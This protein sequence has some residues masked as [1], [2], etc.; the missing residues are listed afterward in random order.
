MARAGMMESLTNVSNWISKSAWRLYPFFLLLTLLPIAL[1]AYSVSQALKHQAEVQ[2]ISGST[3]VARLS[4]TLIGEH[5]GQSTAYLE[6]LA[7]SPSF[8][9]AVSRNDR[10]EI[11][12]QLR[13][14]YALRPDFAFL[15][16]YDLDGNMRAIYPPAP[17]LINRNFSYRDWYRGISR[18]WKPYISEV[19]ETAVSPQQ[20]VAAA[21]VPI[22]DAQGRPIAI[23]MA[24]LALT[25]IDH[26]LSESSLDSE[27]SISILDQ[28]GHSFSSPGDRHYTSND[29]KERVEQ[30]VRGHATD[31]A[32]TIYDKTIFLHYE[33]LPAYGWG[34]LV[35]RQP[36]ALRAGISVVERQAW[37]WGL[38]FALLGV[39]ISVALGSLFV[40]L[41]TSNRFTDLSLDLFCTA[42]FDGFFKR[43]NPAWSKVLGF[44]IEE[45]M[46]RPYLEFVHPEDRR[47][48]VDESDSL[49][50]QEIT[51]AFE[52]RYL[53]KDGS[54]KLL[55]WNAISDPEQKLI[56]GIARDVTQ[57][58]KAER[59]LKESEERFRLLV[60]SVKD[61]AILVLD[62]AG[63]VTSWNE[64]AEHIKG[65]KA[66][67]ILGRHFSCFYT[68]E[69]IQSGKPERELR[70]ATSE[71]RYE[72]EGWRLR[73]DGTR[74]WAS[75]V[76]TAMKDQAG[77][78]RGFAKV[79]RD[80][81]ERKR[82]EELLKESEERH[83]KL[84]ENN[85]HPTW[86]F[87]RETLRFLAVNRAA[88]RNY[89]YSSDE[90]LAMEITDIRPPEDIPKVIEAVGHLTDGKG[91]TG[92]WRHRR[93]DGKIIDVEITSYALSFGG[94]PAEV[95]VAVD[96]T[97]RRQA[98]EERRT[99]TESLAVA[100][101]ELEL[102]NREVE[103]ATQLKSKFLASMSHELRTPLNAIVGFSDLLGE[104]APGQLNAKQ[105]RFVGHIKQGSKHLL[106]LINDILD[107]SKIEAGQ[108]EFR[109]EDFEIKD[110]L[111]EVLSTIRPLA[112]AKNITVNE[113]STAGLFICADR[114]RFKQVLYNL[115]SNAVKFTP[116]GGR[117]EIKAYNQ[118]KRVHVSV[119]D[120]G[121][122]IRPED[123]TL[124]FE[125]FRQVEGSTNAHEGT[126]LG[127]AI[128]KRLVEEQG[129]TISLESELGKGSKFT[130]SFP[131]GDQRS[132][133]EEEAS[134]SPAQVNA[135]ESNPLVLIVDDEE[136]ARELLT[137]YLAPAY[138]TVTADSGAD[139]LEKAKQIRPHAIIL[140][141][142]MAE[143][144]GFETLVALRKAPETA[145]IPVI[146][147]SIV[148]QKKIG[149]AL[150]ATD[151]LVKP[152]PKHI[153]LETLSKYVFASSMDDS[154]ILL[155]DD[156]PKSLE[157][158]AETL[159]AAGYET[160]SVQ[161]GV[162]ALEVLSSKIVDAVLLDL[163]M[164]GMDGF[165]V[166]RHVRSRPN[167]QDLPIFV[168]TGKTLTSEEI[169]LL[170][171]QTQAFFQKNGLWQ[172]QLTTEI[173][174]VL[175][176][177]KRSRAAGQR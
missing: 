4:A 103:R 79:T 65:Y 176:S 162:R 33:P 90:F 94:R 100:N 44:S 116:N 59:E 31:K 159:R 130:I 134:V 26:W 37:R 72:E 69:D 118:T 51:F 113:S 89:G 139:A 68:P 54:Y 87:D 150:G 29:G 36:A 23:L 39:G 174:R 25:T 144:N 112:M 171:S 166:I 175:N 117:V 146:I 173:A 158:L 60:N 48:T 88:V 109:Y 107:L 161:N 122:G 75:V 119:S 169:S 50:R 167:L 78:L 20:P 82:V 129:G 71:G 77:E 86:L 106:Q 165:E 81:T 97:E 27:S 138:R 53:C 135:A 11:I 126:G 110:A 131:M 160:Q 108:L 40:R 115:L 93:K 136:A 151:Y 156:D 120:T 76:L 127:L 17:T 96:V 132:A 30:V 1:F 83:R 49:A 52:N 55:S 111:P 149:F 15:S 74:F 102:R 6:A 101:Q 91:S 140:D 142:L 85:P 155:V 18:Q 124:V 9:E 24:P 10:L 21:A 28:N 56:Y 154:A 170:N 2:A 5:F 133:L 47:A 99:F 42:G 64:G 34:V 41:E 95:V 80:V 114:V 153:L 168:M 7:V 73:K 32:F 61:Y 19:Y 16:T 67:E 123:H 43:L 12:K 125:E 145:D 164:P 66:H 84:F 177:K 148:D 98:E 62:S 58:K 141:V 121:I 147:L 35:D 172:T 57:H 143:G 105:L 14:A 104:Q 45:L 157:L 128:S 137:S 22:T 13:S 3:Q 163:L 63:N 38:L 70:I 152:I 92:S 46:S 8:R